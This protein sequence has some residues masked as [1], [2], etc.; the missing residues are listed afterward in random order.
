MYYFQKISLLILVF[1]FPTLVFGEC[2]CDYE[3]IEGKNGEALKFKIG[4][5]ASIL[6]AGAAG[7]SL[8]LL[9]NRFP[10]LRPETDIFFL[11]KAFAAGVILAT[12][13]IHILP[14]AFDDLSSPC[15]AEYPWGSFP[16]V[17]FTAMMAAIGT[18]MI[19]TFAT[20]YYRRQ[21]SRDADKQVG[22]DHEAAEEHRDDHIHVHSHGHSHGST[23][24]LIRHRIVAQV[25]F[26]III[27]IIISMFYVDENMLL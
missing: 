25:T 20:G 22:V 7:V 4:A 24:E 8:P 14:D 21:H 23:S 5:I 12:G 19:D 1:G 11:V 2:T 6:F 13:F 17:G 15:L 10:A 3:A 27:I 9:G 16:F 26:I 18:L